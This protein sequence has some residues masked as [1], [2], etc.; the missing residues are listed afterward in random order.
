MPFG[1]LL[2]IGLLGLG[3]SII[4]SVGASSAANAQAGAA[5]NAANLQYQLG[6]QSL[7]QQQNQFNTTQQNFA[8]WLAAGSGALSQLE[9]GLGIT[10]QGAPAAPGAAPI[11]TGPPGINGLSGL[12]AQQTVGGVAGGPRS[13]LLYANEGGGSIPGGSVT[14]PNQVGNAQ[15]GTTSIPAGG[16]I[17]YGSLLQGFNQPFVAPTA[18]TEQNDPGY[19][20]R[21]QQ[22]QQALQN[23][24]AAQ[25]GLLSGN[26]GQA[27]E[28]YAQNYASNE[29]SN[30]YNRALTE[31]QQR[32]NIF[33]GNQANTFNRLAA[34][35]GVGQTTA[36]QL[37]QLGQQGSANIANI[38]A[39]TG[40]QVGNSLQNAGAATASGYAGIANSLNGGIGNISQYL[41]LQQAGL[42]GSSNP[43]AEAGSIP[44]AANGG[45]YIPCWVAGELYGWYTP[46]WFAVRNW[47]RDTPRMRQFWLFYKQV[48]ERWA[49][50]IRT[51][52]KLR[53]ETQ[54][55]FDGFLKEALRA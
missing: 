37:G 48:G 34:L 40:Q 47:L 24:A 5:T 23:S 52:R 15:G 6:Q 33:Q 55:L 3:G 20:F 29:Y 18:A 36:S 13:A 44:A 1:G 45:T 17:G 8:P 51:D 27:L 54:E 53:L 28:Q 35:A 31:Y 19:Q 50:A 49:A 25:G 38:N 21:L 39:S 41:M 11:G 4:G 32:Y 12:P 16:Q 2:T 46:K 22:G 26:T 14:A 7:A 10:P 9:T 42:L 30:V 43:L